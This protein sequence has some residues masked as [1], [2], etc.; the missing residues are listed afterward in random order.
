[1][2][3]IKQLSRYEQ[4]QVN[5]AKRKQAMQQA[6]DRSAATRA[7]MVNHINTQASNQVTLTEQVLRS[8]TSVRKTA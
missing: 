4:V 5:S 8:K 7:T 6:I 1:M 2:A 3:Q